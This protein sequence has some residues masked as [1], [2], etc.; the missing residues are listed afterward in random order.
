MR[1]LLPLLGLLV[2]FS[3]CSTSRDFRVPAYNRDQA[4]VHT[5]P[6]E[7]KIVKVW[8]VTG[9]ALDHDRELGIDYYIEVDVVSGPQ[10][11]TK[12]SLPYDQWNVGKPPPTEGS[13]VVVAPSDW[14][15]RAKDTK[16][17]PFGSM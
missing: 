16:G 14:V 10:A 2:L 17:R 9:D 13:I 5:E 8:S 11:G 4:L 7:L 1:L 6:M 12:L 3:G 15:K